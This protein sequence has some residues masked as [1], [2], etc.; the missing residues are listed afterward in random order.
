MLWTIAD[1]EITQ[2]PPH[3]PDPTPEQDN[4]VP[5][6]EIEHPSHSAM[7]SIAPF[8]SGMTPLM[9]SPVVMF[10]G[11]P[12]AFAA[13]TIPPTVKTANRNEYSYGNVTFGRQPSQGEANSR[14]ILMN[15]SRIHDLDPGTFWQTRGI[16][17]GAQILT[18]HHWLCS[19][20]RLNCACLD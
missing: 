2:T 7:D 3:S 5:S 17:V 4:K 15:N 8:S 1:S 9:A 18:E 20:E 14:Q 19:D 16:P 11:S 12:A 6:S 10:M 13:L